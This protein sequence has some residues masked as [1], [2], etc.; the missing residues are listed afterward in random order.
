M[1]SF[2]FQT[3]KKRERRGKRRERSHFFVERSLRMELERENAASYW[4]ISRARSWRE[5]STKHTLSARANYSRKERER[6]RYEEMMHHDES[7]DRISTNDRCNRS[8]NLPR[9]TINPEEIWISLLPNG[10]SVDIPR[11][12]VYI[13]IY[14]YPLAIVRRDSFCR[15]RSYVS[16]GISTIPKVGSFCVQG[17]AFVAGQ[18]RASF[19]RYLRRARG[20][21]ER[22]SGL[23]SW[24]EI[25]ATPIPLLFLF[26][27]LLLFCFIPCFYILPSHDP[28]S[29]DQGG[30]IS[31]S[32]TRSYVSKRNARGNARS[33]RCK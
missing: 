24:H 32:K 20:R 12:R 19:K 31:K 3:K 6:E 5:E 11:I 27:F 22:T 23:L 17:R 8:T 25:R 7:M 1:V 15:T 16:R 18:I 33:Y 2:V 14:I 13:Y 30:V 29:F 10:K 26:F 9:N 4:K 28:D 21:K